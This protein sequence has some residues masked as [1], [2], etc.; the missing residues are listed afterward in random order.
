[1]EQVLTYRNISFTTPPPSTPVLPPMSWPVSIPVAAPVS[2]PAAIGPS[3]CPSGKFKV[4]VIMNFDEYAEETS[5]KIVQTS[6]NTIVDQFQGLA[7]QSKSR[8]IKSSCLDNTQ[9]YLFVISDSY[10]DG[11]QGYLTPGTFEVKVNGVSKGSGGSFKREDLVMFGSAPPCNGID[12]AFTIVVQTDDY[13]SENTYILSRVSNGSIV[14]R[15]RG[16]TSNTLNLEQI[17]LSRDDYRLRL[18]DSSADGMCCGY[19][20]GYYAIYLSSAL[21]RKGAEF[22]SLETTNFTV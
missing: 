11:M 2:A 14:S 4:E 12:K 10:S 5:Y 16:Y 22:G 13:G 15:S 6:T 8:V 20:P 9:M 3:T 21:L 7:S 1:M 18:R 19:G 17:C